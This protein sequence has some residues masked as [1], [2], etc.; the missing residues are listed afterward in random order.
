MAVLILGTLRAEDYKAGVQNLIID[1]TNV[2]E[3]KSLPYIYAWGPRCMGFD[4]KG[5]ACRVL[6]RGSMN[7]ALV[8]FEDGFQA[9]VSRSALRKRK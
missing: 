4:R 3:Q 6:V 7:S 9:I 8:E 5:Q 1:A 2:T